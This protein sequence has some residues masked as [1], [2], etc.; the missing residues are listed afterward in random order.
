VFLLRLPLRGE[1][2]KVEPQGEGWARDGPLEW[3]PVRMLLRVSRLLTYSEED[4]RV[5]VGRMESRNIP[6]LWI[7]GGGYSCMKKA[8]EG[9]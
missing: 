4:E 2:E 1:V 3:G 7:S 8:G 5:L 6:L 9:G